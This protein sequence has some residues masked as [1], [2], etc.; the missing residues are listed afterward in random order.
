MKVLGLI[1]MERDGVSGVAGR[2]SYFGDATSDC[3]F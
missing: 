2:L 1:R 3:V